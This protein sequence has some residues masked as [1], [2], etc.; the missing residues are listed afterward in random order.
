MTTSLPARIA[1]IGGGF[2]GVMTGVNLA[3]LSRRPLH[4]MLINQ[5]YPRGRGVAYGA[6]RIEHLLNVA[7]RNMSA[8]PDMPDHFLEWLRTRSEYDFVPDGELRERFMPRMIYGDYLCGLVQHYLQSP[9]EVVQAS[10]TFV[11]GQAVDVRQE[12]RRAVVHL[13]DGGSV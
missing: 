2:S 3:R 6:R 1:I 12:G 7:A 9:P 8:F 11:E 13:S 5:Q 4:V 10:A